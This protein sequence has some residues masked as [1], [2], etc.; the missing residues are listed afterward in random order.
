MQD[1]KGIKY[2]STV[3]GWSFNHCLSAFITFATP[4]PLILPHGELSI[5]HYLVI[6]H[7]EQWE[8]HDCEGI[9]QTKGHIMYTIG[10]KF[11]NSQTN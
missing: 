5:R 3:P 4:R 11:L 7:N 2:N 10:Y 1:T 8:D 9:T 6:S